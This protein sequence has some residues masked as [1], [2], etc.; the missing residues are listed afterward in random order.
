MKSVVI[1]EGSRVH[2]LVFFNFPAN[3]L[4][5]PDVF[6]AQNLLHP[7]GNHPSKFQLIRFSRFGGVREQTNKQ[8]DKLTHCILFYRVIA[9]VRK[10]KGE[11]K[12]GWGG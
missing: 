2:A 1:I 3:G 7:K 10:I 11:A 5:N 4:A 12:G 9:I 8:T 6:L